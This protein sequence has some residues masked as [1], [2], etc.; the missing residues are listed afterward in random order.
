MYWIVSAL[1]NDKQKQKTKHF[2]A[3]IPLNYGVTVI[4]IPKPGFLLTAPIGSNTFVQNTNQK[5]RR[6]RER[7]R[8]SGFREIGF[9]M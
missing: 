3:N 5:Q 9:T 6:R 7:Q 1:Y 2:C 8:A 4:W